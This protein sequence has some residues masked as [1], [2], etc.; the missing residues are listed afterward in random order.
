M[1]TDEPVTYTMMVGPIQA[2]L[3]S[4][5]NW[6]LTAPSE[7]SDEIV[8]GLIQLLDSQTQTILRHVSPSDG[9]PLWFTF[10][11]I[12][13]RFATSWDTSQA[14]VNE[15]ADTDDSPDIY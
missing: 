7:L 14:T 6:E 3:S 1:A 15:S 9:D 11:T 5:F 4:E 2:E 8:G 10:T 12:A 13:K